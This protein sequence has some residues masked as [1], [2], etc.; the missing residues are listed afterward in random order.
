M[1]TSDD[2]ASEKESKESAG[3]KVLGALSPAQVKE[4]IGWGSK[5][6]TFDKFDQLAD[7][8]FKMKKG[9]GKDKS[10]ASSVTGVIG[11]SHYEKDGKVVLFL[12]QQSGKTTRD[13][14]RIN[15]YLDPMDYRAVAMDDVSG[16]PLHGEMTIIANMLRIKM[17]LDQL[18]RV[19]VAGK[20]GCCR[21]CSGVLSKLGVSYSF[22]K[23]SAW[24][25]ETWADP[26][27]KAGLANPYLTTKKKF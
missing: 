4:I 18:T 10:L 21:L 24:E 13:M 2:E 19:G 1:D 23:Q 15:E 17:P 7:E 12:A 26:W 20:K 6:G 16:S 22:T 14:D 8:I 3:V 9:K 27:A 11:A 25:E 5:E